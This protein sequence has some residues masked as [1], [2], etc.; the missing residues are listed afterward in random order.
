[1]NEG[2]RCLVE[3]SD[4][5][6]GVVI[7]VNRR[8]RLRPRVALVLDSNK[9][10]FPLAKIVNLTDL[11]DQDGSSE[12]SIVK[13]LQPGEYGINPVEYLPEIDSR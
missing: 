11:E 4:G 5:S 9:E 10:P 1:M 2:F 12:T 6:I 13:V 8:R 7:N 3:L